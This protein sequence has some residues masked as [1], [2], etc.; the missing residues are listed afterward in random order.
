MST[1][2]AKHFVVIEGVIG[3]G[4]STLAQ[5]LSEAWDA[6][7]V[8]EEVEENPYLEEFYRDRR[9]Y[10]FQ[11][12]I[13]FLLSRYQ[14]QQKLLQRDI[15]S[16]KVVSD[17]LFQKDRIFANVNLSDKELGL[18]ERLFPIL[19]RDVP[20]PDLV[21]YLQATVETLLGRIQK[22]GRSFERDMSPEYLEALA[23]AYNYFFFHYDA[24]PLLVVDTNSLDFVKNADQRE[25]LLA[26]VEEH[27]GGTVYYRPLGEGEPA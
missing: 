1:S 8:M 18:Y 5:Y 20:T 27:P 14:Q 25:D 4:K 6:T 16:P 2:R 17:Y 22:R 10:A 24:A 12:Q 23:E 15:F 19:E 3:V 21:V 13:T 7:L 11:T 9:R 26:R